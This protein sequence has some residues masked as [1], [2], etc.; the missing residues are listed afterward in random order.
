M[1]KERKEKIAGEIEKARQAEQEAADLESRAQQEKEQ[2]RQQERE[3]LKK[4]RRQ[5]EENSVTAASESQE[6]A[7]V[8]RQ[9]AVQREQQMRAIMH[10]EVSAQVLCQVAQETG[11]ALRREEYAARRREMS[12][13][14]VRQVEKTVSLQP[15]DVLNIL[16]GNKLEV[17]VTGAQPLTEN[18][19]AELQRALDEKA[20]AAR[21]AEEASAALRRAIIGSAGQPCGRELGCR[22]A[23][24]RGRHGI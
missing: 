18:Q 7:N 22:C 19:L 4:T 13:R 5:V 8:L 6:A 20:Y 10:K 24:A 9:S 15:S 14:F 21:Q 23:Y 16:S 3:L 17:T 2:S 11:K 1:F 12:D